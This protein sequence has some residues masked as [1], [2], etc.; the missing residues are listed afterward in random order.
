LNEKTFIEA[1]QALALR[2]LKEGGPDN[3]TRARYAFR[4]CTARFPTSFELE[5]LLQFWQNQFS[6]FDHDTAVAVQV[7]ASDPS[8]LPREVN[9]HQA[10]AWT[11]LSRALLNLDETVT[12]E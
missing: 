3:A 2:V 11:M 5:K 7:A 8:K 1:A 9:L 10:A 6:D 12:R 4:L